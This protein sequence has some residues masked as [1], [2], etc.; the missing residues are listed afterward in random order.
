MI[1]RTTVTSTN[2]FLSFNLGGGSISESSIIH[3]T[4][5]VLQNFKELY[6]RQ[7]DCDVI[8]KVKGR[9]FPAHRLI[10]KTQSPVFASAFRIDMMERKTGIVDVEDCDPSVFSDFL[11]FLYCGE[12]EK[13]SE[14]NVFSLFTVADKY[15]IS[16]LRA[17]CMEFMKQNLSVNTFCDTIAFAL[18]Y[19][20]AEL[21][22]LSTDFF[23]TNLTDIIMTVKWQSFLL[24]NPIQGNELMIKALVPCTS[25]RET[26]LEIQTHRDH[27]R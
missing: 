26:D 27:G 14:D 13:L 9:E 11:Y 3:P 15:D 8:I 19:D 7:E 1:L 16:D 20:D 4:N 23:A 5:K 21:I 2:Y 12:V 24:E 25:Q 10:L 6:L 17:M 22:K 18:L